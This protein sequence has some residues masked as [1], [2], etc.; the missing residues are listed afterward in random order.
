[1]NWT[2]QSEEMLKNWTDAQ[3]KMW[4]SWLEMM[5][6]GGAQVQNDLWLKSI[7]MME[8]A[9]KESLSTQSN[10]MRMWFDALD[11]QTDVPDEFMKWAEQAQE[12]NSQ[13][14]ATQEKMW[15]GWFDMM[16]QMGSESLTV[17]MEDEGKK[18]FAMWQE[19]AQKIMDANM[20]FAQA[21][22][23]STADTNSK[24]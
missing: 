7:E 13:W 19:S 8:K 12:M 11:R 6:P 4:N 15:Q 10:W 20:K 18:A 17:D 3:Q 23:M 24:K 5:K 14:N 22:G 16:K 1:M 21:W 2:Q 9:V